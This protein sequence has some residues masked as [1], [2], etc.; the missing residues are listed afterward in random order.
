MTFPNV[1]N[2]SVRRLCVNETTGI[3]RPRGLDLV[4]TAT[5]Y[6]QLAN[7]EKARAHLEHVSAIVEHSRIQD[8]KVH[9]GM[10][11]ATF[12]GGARVDYVLPS[13]GLTIR[14]GDVFWPA[15]GADD[16]EGHRWARLASD[17]RPAWIDVS[18]P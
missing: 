16:L 12:S 2:L 17:H 9:A 1:P 11:T 10:L 5:R 6:H 15:E 7:A 18:W 14:D 3:G 8:P 13:D 4:F